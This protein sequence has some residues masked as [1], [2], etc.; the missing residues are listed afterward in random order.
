MLSDS[1]TTLIFRGDQKDRPLISGGRTTGRFEA[2]TP[3]LWRVYIPEVANYGFY[4]E[5]LYINGERRFRAQ[6]PNHGDFFKPK[7]IMCEE[8]E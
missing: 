3:Q 7:R 6:T 1:K 5:Q 8:Q 4:F 2:V